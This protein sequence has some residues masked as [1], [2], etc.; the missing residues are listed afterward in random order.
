MEE[1]IRNYCVYKHTAPNGK[2]YIGITGQSPEMRWR[3]GYGYKE[4]I[5]F[6]ECYTK[7]WMG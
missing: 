3:K 1:V 7:I 4:Q 6:L 2:V 5:L